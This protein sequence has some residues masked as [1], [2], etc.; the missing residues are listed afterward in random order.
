MS[1]SGKEYPSAEQTNPC[2]NHI[3]ASNWQK[4]TCQGSNFPGFRAALGQSLA[5]DGLGKA[6]SQ[7]ST[8]DTSF[9]LPDILAGFQKLLVF[10]CEMP[11]GAT[12]QVTKAR[13]LWPLGKKWATDLGKKRA[14]EDSSS[15]VSLSSLGV[16]QGVI[17]WRRG[18]T[19]V[20][21]SHK[22]H[23]LST[24]PSPARETWGFSVV[25]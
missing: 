11:A 20:C 17:Q 8:K 3:N 13:V 15:P 25:F 7:N 6:T 19:L 12:N 18:L 1:P 24:K 14:T 21:S 4:I 16:G 2:G 9:C 22:I 10:S 5:W 23:P